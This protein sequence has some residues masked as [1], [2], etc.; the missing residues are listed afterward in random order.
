VVEVTWDDATALDGWS[1]GEE[2]I[3]P[4]LVLSVGFLVKKTKT[5]I[6]LAQDIAPD[7]HRCGRGQIPRGMVKRI[8]VLKKKDASK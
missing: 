2:E 8:K 1:S 5:H 4:C 3:K 7:G 6:V